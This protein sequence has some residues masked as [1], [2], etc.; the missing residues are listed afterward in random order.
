MET[1]LSRTTLTLPTELIEAADLV[2]KSGKVKSR[3][4]FITQALRHELAILK[5]VEIDAAFAAMADD[6]EYRAESLQIEAEFSTASWEV[7][8]VEGLAE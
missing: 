4:E 2:V 1:H 6:V 8:Q 7:F 3:N 5:R